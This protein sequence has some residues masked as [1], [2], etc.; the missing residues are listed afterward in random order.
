MDEADKILNNYITIF[1]KDYDIYFINCRFELEFDN[2]LTMN[3]ETNYIHNIEIEKINNILLYAIKCHELMGYKFCCI[4]QM[5]IPI[6]N[7]K[8][9]IRY[10]NYI[11]NPANMFGRRININIAKNSQLINLF[12]RM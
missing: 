1:N 4:N 11:N 2:K 10:E 3:T 7:D 6:L 9:N 5:N 12:D 8:C